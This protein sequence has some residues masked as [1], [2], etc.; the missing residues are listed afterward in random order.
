MKRTPLQETLYFAKYVRPY[1][2]FYVFSLF[3]ML[4]Q[5]ILGLI[6]P[7][8]YKKLIDEVFNA[9]DPGN[10]VNLF[11]IIVTI[12]AA[13][14]IA[15][16]GLGMAS[17]IVT[18]R[19]TTA[20]TNTLEYELLQKVHSVPISYHDKHAPGEI[21]PRLYNDPPAVINFYLTFLPQLVSSI[22]R[23]FIVFFVIVYHLWWAGL[24]ALLPIIPMWIISKFNV[25][26]FKQ[27][28]DKQFEK[29]QYLYTRVLDM[30]HGI[31]IVRIFNKSKPEMQ[32]FQVVQK[33][34]RQLQISAT[35][36]NA[37]MSP[38]I[39]NVGKLGGLIVFLAGSARLLNLVKFDESTFTLG[40]LFMILSYVWQLAGP[41]TNIANFSS[42]FGNVRA[43]SIR[44]IDLLDENETNVEFNSLVKKN[45]ENIVEFA[46][47]CF[48]YVSEKPVLKD[49]SFS[50]KPGEKVGLVGPSGSGKTTI[51]NLMCGFYTPDSGELSIN[52]LSPSAAIKV[53]NNKAFLSLAMQ[54]GNLFRGTIRDNLGYAR[55]NITE[56]EMLDILDIV[57]AK[58]FVLGLEKGLNTIVGEGA[59]KLSSGQMQ[60]IA[61]ARAILADS[62]ILIMDEATS[63]IDLW[64]EQKIFTHLLQS[65][66]N[67]TIICASHRLHLMQLMDKVFVLRNGV[68]VHQGTHQ[69]LLKT[70]DYYASSWNLRDFDGNE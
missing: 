57:D 14:R 37:W 19:V 43:A 30:L 61:L 13:I 6:Q 10:H 48:G 21:F 50:I 58:T 69:E 56:N 31:R 23:A 29:Y 8:Y 42:Q 46:D 59:R 2:P 40:T 70:D 5:T 45:T 18:T 28:S 12:L 17:S 20:C 65:S 7:V 51:L 52:G 34:L 36:R 33:D 49:L 11:L 26:Y 64:T 9:P 16:T 22:I 60:R 67:K 63:W 25:K 4:G 47:V 15:S 66:K 27:L 3:T 55:E 41:V 24:I 53:N 54:D 39:S 32:R 62:L 38:L 1:R 68:I 35:N 44:L